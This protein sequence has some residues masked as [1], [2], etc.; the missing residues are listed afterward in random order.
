MPDLVRKLSTGHTMV[1][2]KDTRTLYL[3]DSSESCGDSKTAEKLVA[4]G[5]V[6][7]V[8]KSQLQTLQEAMGAVILLGM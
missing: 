1:F 8:E 3:V 7:K 4:S 6:L 5:K 2:D